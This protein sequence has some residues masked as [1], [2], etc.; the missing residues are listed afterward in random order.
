MDV[1]QSGRVGAQQAGLVGLE[2][3]V[4]GA[5]GVLGKQVAVAAEAVSGG[6]SGAAGVLPFGLGGQPE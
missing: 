4:V 1:E 2:V 3:G 5:P 6:R